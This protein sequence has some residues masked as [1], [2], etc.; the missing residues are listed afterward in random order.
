[1]EDAAFAVEE[2]LVWGGADLLRRLAEV[3]KWPL[4]RAVWTV[5]RGVVWPLEERTDGWSGSLRAASAGGLAL[6]AVGAAVLGLVIAGGGS[7]TQ[8]RETSAPPSLYR[9]PT[10]AHAQPAP[11]L[12][13][14]TPDFKAT[15]ENAGSK[16]A[17]EATAPVQSGAK[18]STETAAQGTTPESSPTAAATPVDVAPPA[19]TAV[20]H[21]FAGAF[22]L[23]EIGKTS[24]KVS[25]TI[26]A[27]TTPRLARSLLKKPPRLPANT[28][29]PKAK[30]LNIVPGPKRGDAYTMSVSLLRV[31]IT[32]EL[33]IDM[34]RQK[35]TGDWQV[36]HIEG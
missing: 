21:R 2:R 4:E 8:V 7:A 33:R 1:M 31:G 6:L 14:P 36:A 20:A 16:L 9:A 23:Y 30:V 32:S 15:A 13:G 35:R 29:V 18:A 28:E 26:N 5:E 34:E 22:V 17:D 11:A 24:P 12:R 10:T 27:T 25:A 3:V 19:A